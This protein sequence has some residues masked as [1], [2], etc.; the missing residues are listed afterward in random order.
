M[1]DNGERSSANPGTFPVGP[2]LLV[3]MRLNSCGSETS[4]SVSGFLMSCS[5]HSSPSSGP[6]KLSNYTYTNRGKR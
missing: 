4:L 1:R 6:L 5:L 3:N 2:I